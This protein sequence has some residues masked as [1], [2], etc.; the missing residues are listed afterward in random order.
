MSKQHARKPWFS[1]DFSRGYGPLTPLCWQGWATIAGMVLS[2]IGPNLISEWFGLVL[3]PVFGI[4]WYLPAA[5]FWVTF[6]AIKS[7]KI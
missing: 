3:L 5:L 6:I 1:I 4:V 7:E 2:L